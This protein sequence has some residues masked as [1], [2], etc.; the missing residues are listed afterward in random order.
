MK[1]T[2]LFASVCSLI[3]FL[4]GCSLQLN[5]N[6]NA[7]SGEVTTMEEPAVSGQV[8]DQSEPASADGG[9]QTSAAPGN[10]DQ[11]TSNQT[12]NN[13]PT[14]PTMIIDQNKS[15]TAIL[16]TEAGDIE[17]ALNA[18]E[19]PTTANNFVWLAKQGFYNG[20]IFHRVMKG[21]MIQGGDPKG[22]GSGNPGYRFNDEPFTGEYTRGT[23]AMA[24]SGPNTNGSQFF[25]MHA[26][27]PL[28]KQ[29]VIFGQVTKGLEA[30]DK[31]ATAPVTTG[32]SGEPSK[33]VTPV[34]VTSVEII[35]K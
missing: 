19:T 20:T 34:K 5:N 3:I 2:L 33:P 4:A 22:D 7:P 12:T 11:S 26:N 6:A 35:E 29:Y 25:I 13:Q 28:P 16:H 9:N 21:F 32:P 8:L 1:K 18:K 10:P 23:V 17:V 31:I 14:M 27:Y 15:Y 30:V 24:N